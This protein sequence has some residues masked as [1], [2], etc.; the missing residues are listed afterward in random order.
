LYVILALIWHVLVAPRV[1]LDE[2]NNN[3]QLDRAEKVAG[4]PR[5]K[6]F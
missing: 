2:R 3:V 5:K 4:V 1:V 6:R